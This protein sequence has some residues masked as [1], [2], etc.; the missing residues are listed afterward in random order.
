MRGGTNGENGRPAQDR[1]DALG[2]APVSVGVAAVRLCAAGGAV[3]QEGRGPRDD[4]L[5]VRA[6][7][8]GEAGLDAFRPLGL[9]AQDQHGLVEGRR[10][11]LDA[12][13]IGEDEAGAAHQAH[14]L[15]VVE[16]LDERDVGQMRVLADDGPRRWDWDGA[17]GRTASPGSPSARR[18]IARTIRSSGSPKLSR[19]CAVIRTRSSSGV[20]PVL[21]RDRE[22]C[23]DD[24][25]A[26]QEDPA[27]RH[28]LG[29]EGPGGAARRHEVR[30]GD[31]VH[32]APVHFLGERV[33]EVAGA[34]AGLDVA[35]AHATV[36]GGDRGAHRRRRVALDEQP[37]GLL[38]GEDRVDSGEHARR[39]GVHRLVG[40]HEVEV[41][42]GLQGEEREHLVEHLAVLRGGAE[43]RLAPGLL[44]EAAG[45]RGPS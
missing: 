23:V 35:D 4:L 27:V 18:P 29:H 44:A 5:L 42:V 17:R 30:V 12:A 9:L 19:R 15:E 45:G 34:Q 21:A 37:V 2:G 39:E 3:G 25:V 38:A 41:D 28:V 24:G 1:R 11:L 40:T 6:H 10:F 20:S 36:E 13:G 33:L 16:G 7:E 32:H 8:L 22:Q 31:E 43:D 26:G 14:E